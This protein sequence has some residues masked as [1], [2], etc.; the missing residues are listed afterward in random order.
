MKRIDFE[1]HY[2]AERIAAVAFETGEELPIDALEKQHIELS[3]QK[4]MEWY[5]APVRWRGLV[6][7][8]LWGD[9]EAL[10]SL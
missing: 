4:L 8:Q 5:T 10:D 9:D 7:M 1:D 2:W 6:V 3:K